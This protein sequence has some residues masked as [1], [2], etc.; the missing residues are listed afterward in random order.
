ML[1]CGIALCLLAHTGVP[2]C[3]L[4]ISLLLTTAGRGGAPELCLE[5]HPQAGYEFCLPEC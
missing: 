3:A 2:E 5:V 1:G 4:Q